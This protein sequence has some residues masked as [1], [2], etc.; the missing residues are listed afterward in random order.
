MIFRLFFVLLV[1]FSNVSHAQPKENRVALVMGN[2]AYKTA[3]LKNPTNDAKDMA[4]KLKGMGFTVVERNNLTA[5]QIG[6]TLREF[7]SKL[8]PGSVALVYYAGHGLQIKGENYFPTVDAEI[9]GEE[10]VPNQSLAM[11]QIMDVLEDA[12][13]RLNLVFLDACRNNPYQRSFRSSSDGLSRV[14]APSGTLISFAT[15]PG[16]VAADGTG[17]NGLYTGALL[18]AMDS[19]GDQ[20]E[21][22]LKRVVTRVKAGSNNQ[23]EP[24]MEGSIDGEFCFGSCLVRTAQTGVSDDRALWD[25]VKD[26]RNVSDLKAYL[27]KFPQG[28]FSE[29]AANRIK[30]AEQSSAPQV[31][32][33]AP[34][35]PS[36]K[37]IVVQQSTTFK[38]CQDCPEMVVIPAGNFLMG[39]NQ[40]NFSKPV[41]NVNIRGFF[42]GKT[43]VTQGQW[44]AVMGNNPNPLTRCFSDDCPVENVSWNQVQIF[45]NRLNSITGKKY[46]LPSESEWEYVALAGI[47]NSSSLDDGSNKLN[48]YSWYFDNSSGKSHSVA[49]KKPNA[50]GIYDMHGNVWEWTQDC[51]NE[52]Y[53]GAPLDGSAWLTGDC[54]RRVYKGGSWYSGHRNLRA[55][56]R[57]RFSSDRGNFYGGFRVAMSNTPTLSYADRLAARI[58]PNITYPAQAIPGNPRVAVEVQVAPD[59]TIINRKILESSGYKAWDDAMLRAIDKTEILPKDTDGSV[60]P[61]I[62]FSFRPLD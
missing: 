40:D 7:R 58:K 5:K 43:E 19:R 42:I 60:P 50:F 46:R 38:D 2:S 10:D 56:H 34:T 62:V 61:L 52:N 21:Q 48:D 12:K 37:P 23:Q 35:Q 4:A 41:R 24:W 9:A 13:T 45:I 54:T 30:S 11:R 17:R 6:S 32:S 57:E 1:V 26:S 39:S 3:P 8:T 44:K 28:L 55:S 51:W 20:I 53:S 14:N 16:S 22:V 25:S 36:F 15:R 49:G 27:N 18:E 59:G 47:S 33:A 31:M 29:V